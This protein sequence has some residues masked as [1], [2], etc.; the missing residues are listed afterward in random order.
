MP[1]GDAL[2]GIARVLGTSVDYILTGEEPNQLRIP[3]IGIASAGEGWSTDHHGGHEPILFDITS[4]DALA[5]EI[6]GDSM[7]PVYRDGD[8]LVCSKYHGKHP[9]NLIGLDCAVMTK[10]G[11]GYIKI[12]KRGT[13]RGRFNLKSYNP[14]FDD[15]EN[16][17]IEWLAPVQWIKRGSR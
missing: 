17:E 9:D 12:L 8:F 13:M 7:S 16:V 14:V 1:G 15:I 6:R 2:M 4:A 5:I 11:D 10:A 3:V